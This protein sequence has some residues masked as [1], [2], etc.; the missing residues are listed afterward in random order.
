MRGPFQESTRYQREVA[1]PYPYSAT[2]PSVTAVE[3]TRAIR[4]HRGFSTATF[5]IVRMEKIAL[6]AN[7]GI[8][9]TGRVILASRVRRRLACEY[10]KLLTLA[11]GKLFNDAKP[12]RSWESL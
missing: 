12:D 1:F 11:M 9:I 3:K 5:L 8:A 10:A 2:R 7:F 4:S 6:G